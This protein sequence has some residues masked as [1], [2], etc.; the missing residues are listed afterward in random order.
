MKTFKLNKAGDIEFAEDNNIRIV[1]DAEELI[2]S[3]RILLSTNQGEWFLKPSFGLAYSQILGRKFWNNKTE[4]RDVIIQ[5]FRQEP[6]IEEIKSLEVEYDRDTRN[7]EI[8]FSVEAC[9][10]QIVE[11]TIE[12]IL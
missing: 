12:M 4:I 7:L 9:N 2:Q 10:G 1:E 11:D 6:R 5:T 3:L 8:N